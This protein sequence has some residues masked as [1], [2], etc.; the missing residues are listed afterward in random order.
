MKNIIIICF[1]TLLTYCITKSRTILCCVSIFI[2]LY[3][4]SR[5]KLTKH[6][7]ER[8]VKAFGV[9]TVPLNIM[10]SMVLPYILLRST[11]FVQ[12]LAYLINQLFSRRFTHIEHM[13]LSYPISWIG[14]QYDTKVMEELFG[15]AVIDNG[16]ITFLYQYGIIG[17]AIFCIFSVICVIRLIK[18]RKNIWVVVFIVMAA[19]GLL[20]NVYTSIGL[21][22]LV[23]FWAYIFSDLNSIRGKKA[24]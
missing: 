4:L 13:F 11:G 16:Y 20:E 2:I 5:V 6:I 15:Y 12:K 8:L 24:K 17:L 21:N 19:E 14:G 3:F 1:T 10:I 22:L 18:S 9:I 23:V 7:T